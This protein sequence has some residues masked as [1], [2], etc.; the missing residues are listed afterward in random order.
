MKP[1]TK[2]AHLVKRSEDSR[3]AYEAAVI[4]ALAVH[5]IREVASAAGNKSTSTIQ[6]IKRKHERR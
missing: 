5:S 4:E 2:V 6:A 3:A 1:L